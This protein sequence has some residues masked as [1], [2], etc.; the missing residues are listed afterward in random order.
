[1]RYSIGQ[2]AFVLVLIGALTG[3][4]L[5]QG[6]GTSNV[7]SL[8]S[9]GTI[10]SSSLRTFRSYSY[11]LSQG[12]GQQVNNSLLDASR[13]PYQLRPG[14]SSAG[15]GQS[16]FS[17]SS[18]SLPGGASSPGGTTRTLYQ[19]RSPLE[20]MTASP[21]SL[22]GRLNQQIDSSQ[23]FSTITVDR[24]FGVT[25]LEMIDRDQPLVSFVPLG[26]QGD[27]PRFLRE[28]ESRVRA[29]RY[30]RAMEQYRLAADIA[31]DKPEV[32]LGM[33]HAAIGLGHYNTAA[34]HLSQAVA[35]MAELPEAKISIRSFF[36][37]PAVFVRLRDGLRAQAEDMQIIPEPWF[38]LSYLYWFDNQ[39]E[40]AAEALR[41]AAAHVHEPR[42]AESVETFWEGFVA[43][44]RVSDDLIGE[45]PAE[46]AA[47]PA[48]AATEPPTSQP[49]E[50]ISA[51]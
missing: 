44:G 13:N 39:P 36:E 8:S 20:S 47:E 2:F 27:F 46:Q 37:S 41:N 14:T 33:L 21:M 9:P 31:R 18:F 29:G 25:D 22:A 10:G 42:L 19:S 45:A 24:V 48:P 50:P 32:R 7:G 17:G 5:A 23:S 43:T 1:M 34:Y 6:R 3:S 35:A 11:G 26:A 38:V 12:S 40:L 49:A 16:G 51:S 30:I 4:A 15:T 28:G